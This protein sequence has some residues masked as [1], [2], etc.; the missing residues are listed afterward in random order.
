[1]VEEIEVTVT[2]ISNSNAQSGLRVGDRQWVGEKQEADSGNALDFSA[3]RAPP[4]IS[5]L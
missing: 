4:S 5:T 3:V 1:M 2:S